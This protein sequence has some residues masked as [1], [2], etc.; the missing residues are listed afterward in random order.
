MKAFFETLKN[1]SICENVI[2]V[3]STVKP[4]TKVALASL[5]DTLLA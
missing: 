5:A 3:K 2:T 1:I 4:E